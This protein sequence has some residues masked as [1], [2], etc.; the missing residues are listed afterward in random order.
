MD[1][2]QEKTELSPGDDVFIIGEKDTIFHKKN[3]TIKEILPS[4]KVS[5]HFHKEFSFIFG[6]EYEQGQTTCEF[7]PKDLKKFILDEQPEVK[8]NRIYP[9]YYHTLY[10]MKYKFSPENNCMHECCTNKAVK[11]IL[12]NCW[13]T[14]S[15]YDVCEDHNKDGYC[16]DGFSM[17]PDYQPTVKKV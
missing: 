8:A 10:T 16:G 13:G 17:T 5:V 1:T 14:V 11:R 7:D 6:F 12:Y 3:G 9:N 15:E 4:G 2:N